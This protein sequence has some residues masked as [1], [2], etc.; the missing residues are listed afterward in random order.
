MKK[1]KILLYII[2]FGVMLSPGIKE[3]IKSFNAECNAF[4]AFLQLSYQ[5]VIVKK[6]I[7]RDE[8]DYHTIEIKS[9]NNIQNEKLILDY[10]K[11]GFYKM[12][13]VN[14]TIYKKTGSDTIFIDNNSGKKRYVLN[15]GCK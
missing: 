14:D 13:N 15:F 6:Y 4:K 10:D 8:H 9:F 3:I 7:D 11:S 1:F 5:G 2:F 12:I